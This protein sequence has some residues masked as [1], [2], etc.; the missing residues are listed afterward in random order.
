MLAICRCVS[1]LIILSA[2]LLSAPQTR[3]QNGVDRPLLASKAG[4]DDGAETRTKPKPEVEHKLKIE[5]K[6]NARKHSTA[7]KKKNTKKSIWSWLK[8][9]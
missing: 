5:P 4:L 6:V 3:P 9:R 7:P 8:K 2:P 1:L